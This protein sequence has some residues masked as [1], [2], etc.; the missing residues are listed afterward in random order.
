[1]PKRKLD[2]LPPAAFQILL[3]LAGEDLH[4]YGIMRQVAHQTGG[5]MRLGPGTLYSS[6]QSLLEE[7]L[8]EEINPNDAKD[9]E[10]DRRRVYRLS[11]AGRKLARNE[12]ERL[13]DLLRVARA[14]NILRGDYV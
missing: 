4:G 1:M 2:P 11:A 9:A 13:A 10:Q 6:I 5:R 12:A 7:K 3:S 14:K 8:I